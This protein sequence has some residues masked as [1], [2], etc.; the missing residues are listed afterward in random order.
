MI[1]LITNGMM[2]NMGKRSVLILFLLALFAAGCT[3]TASP[4]PSGQTEQPDN[5]DTPD[6]P[7]NP[8]TPPGPVTP[9]PSFALAGGATELVFSCSS[10]YDN[11]QTK[12]QALTEMLA[13][14]KIHPETA[15]VS[16]GLF[17]DPLGECR[18]GME[19]YE[20]CQMSQLRED[21]AD[22]ESGGDDQAAG[23]VP[24]V[25]ETA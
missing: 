8:P 14:D 24:K 6:N 17:V 9:T 11:L 25:P 15:Y 18:R 20:K 19:W 21:A 10:N 2:N 13:S 16:C 12:V 7:D 22:D 5:P 23:Q 3:P 1:T 4:D